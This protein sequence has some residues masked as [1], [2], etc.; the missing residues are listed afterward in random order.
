LALHSPPI[1]R[2]AF[3]RLADCATI[4]LRVCDEAGKLNDIGLKGRV[5]VA[6]FLIYGVNILA[7]I[8]RPYHH[9]DQM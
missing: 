1:G 4:D 8:A 5:T 3:L 7:I 2:L 9:V 6:C